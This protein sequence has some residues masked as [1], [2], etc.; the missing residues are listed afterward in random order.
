MRSLPPWAREKR[1]GSLNRQGAPCT[2]SATKANA[3]TVRAPTPGVSSKSA[4][5]DWSALGGGGKIAVQT[6]QLNVLRPDVVMS[7]QDEMRQWSAATV[8]VD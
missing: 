4:K 6:P 7:G 1:A 5:V 2:T 8:V 3:R